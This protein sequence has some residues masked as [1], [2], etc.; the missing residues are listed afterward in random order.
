MKFLGDNSP[1]GNNSGVIVRGAEV[2]GVVVLGGSHRGQLSGE[3][4][5][6]GALFRG[7]FPRGESGVNFTRGNFT[8]ALVWEA[9]V[10]REMS[11]YHWNPA[12][13]YLLLL[14]INL[15]CKIERGLELVFLPHFLH[16]FSRKLFLWLLFFYLMK[17]HCLVAFTLWDIG[18][19]VN[20]NCSL[21]R[22]WRH[23]FWI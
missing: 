5:S 7:N 13:N 4:L 8:G 22:L 2:R 12:A 11:G 23:K 18:Q 6:S 21:I 16:Y 1:G 10:Q 9:V 19:Y 15:F 3:L 20:C 17:F 14:D